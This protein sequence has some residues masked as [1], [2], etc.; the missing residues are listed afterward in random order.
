MYQITNYTRS[1]N[2]AQPV[3]ITNDIAIFASEDKN[4][5]I[6][7]MNPDDS[8]EL[9]KGNKKYSLLEIKP[10][11]E[12]AYRIDYARR[13]A[14]NHG[15]VTVEVRDETNEVVTDI[16]W[17]LFRGYTGNQIRYFNPDQKAET[18]FALA[19][20]D[21]YMFCTADPCL[22]C[23]FACLVGMEIYAYSEKVGLI[24]DGF[25]KILR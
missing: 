4:D 21:A 18:V 1:T 14:K 12:S 25:K 7:D 24:V 15:V 9:V 11:S 16:K 2:K 5:F 23:N 20:E 10:S 13:G 17:I 6:W 19:K 3:R 22:E 8:T